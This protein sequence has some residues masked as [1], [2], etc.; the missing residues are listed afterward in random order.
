VKR[1][2]RLILGTIGVFACL[3]VLALAAFSL[4]TTSAAGQAQS[5]NTAAKPYDESANAAKDISAAMAQVKADHKRVLV[6]FGANWCPDC[7]VLS[8][9]F[10]DSAVKPYLDA[11]F[12]VVKVDVGRMNKNQ[13]INAK[14]GNP[15][16]KGIPAVVVL[17]SAE[18]MIASTQGG[19]LESARNAT[20][21]DIL[22]YLKKWAPDKP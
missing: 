10:E 12:H 4:R 20:V 17:D 19:E 13:D 9:L 3:F 11:H 1:Q 22:N 18:H 7:I 2:Y 14:Y 5:G 16:G 6:D 21:Q 8:K 15:I